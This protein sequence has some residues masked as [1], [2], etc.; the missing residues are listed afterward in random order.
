MGS[1]LITLWLQL[2]RIQVGEKNNP[3]ILYVFQQRLRDFQSAGVLVELPAGQNQIR[4]KNQAHSNSV[5][6][7]GGTFDQ[8][9]V[10]LVDALQTATRRRVDIRDEDSIFQG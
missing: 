2:F 10:V 5:H 7:V 3:R 6:R 8:V 9:T 4:D 1:Q